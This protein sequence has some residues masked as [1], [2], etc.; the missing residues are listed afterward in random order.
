MSSQPILQPQ[1]SFVPT[2]SVE[3]DIPQQLP[4]PP[5]AQAPQSTSTTA[6]EAWSNLFNALKNSGN[7]KI[8]SRQLSGAG[9]VDALTKV[10][11]SLNEK[12]QQCLEQIRQCLDDAK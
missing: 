5:L 3:E 12:Y 6:M 9:H 4:P 10:H 1:Q 7:K 2:T 11:A 8:P